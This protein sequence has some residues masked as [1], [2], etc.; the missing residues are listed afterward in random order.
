VTVRVRIGKRE[1]GR[2]VVAVE[3]EA[4]AAAARQQA[5]FGGELVHR[6]AGGRQQKLQASL[7]SALAEA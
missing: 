6:L 1:I 2:L 3:I 4:S 5:V 7:I